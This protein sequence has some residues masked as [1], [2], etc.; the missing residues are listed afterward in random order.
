MLARLPAKVLWPAQIIFKKRR[1]RLSDMQNMS[2][3]LWLRIVALT[4]NRMPINL[5]LAVI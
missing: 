4:N 3:N 2:T 1:L 5:I